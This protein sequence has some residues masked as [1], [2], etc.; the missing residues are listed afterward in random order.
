[1]DMPNLHKRINKIVG[2]IKAIDKMIEEDIPC[3]EVLIQVNAVK[4]AIHKVGQVILE[5]HLRH[6]VREGLE[7]G[8][9]ERTIAGFAKAV[10]HFS[11][12]R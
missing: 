2:Q 3:E 12:I 8:D 1:M 10:E 4:S 11:R 6:C 5:G 7:H 9:A